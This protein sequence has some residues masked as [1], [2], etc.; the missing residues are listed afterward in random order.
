MWF[1][2]SIDDLQL[3]GFEQMFLVAVCD[4]RVPDL[5]KHPQKLI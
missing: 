4:S 2:V 1:R 5:V 3:S